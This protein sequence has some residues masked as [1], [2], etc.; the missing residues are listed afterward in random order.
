[1]MVINFI[2]CLAEQQVCVPGE[3]TSTFY[4]ARSHERPP[5]L[6]D[7]AEDPFFVPISHDEKASPI[8]PGYSQK[9]SVQEAP[10]Q[11]NLTMISARALLGCRHRNFTRFHS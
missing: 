8:T 4:G 1:M 5:I 2:R 7:K 6:R 11:F 3:C 9:H 10:T